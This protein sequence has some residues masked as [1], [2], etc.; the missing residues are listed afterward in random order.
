MGTGMG[1][2]ICGRC[3]RRGCLCGAGELPLLAEAAV[4]GQVARYLLGGGGREDVVEEKLPLDRLP[5][6]IS[7]PVDWGAHT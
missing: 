6:G 7:T 5:V 3:C 1:S 4:G 2:G